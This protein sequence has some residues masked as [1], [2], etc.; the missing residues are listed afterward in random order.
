[1][2]CVYLESIIFTEL[3]LCLEIKSQIYRSILWDICQLCLMQDK[4]AEI[5]IDYM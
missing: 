3:V 5:N 1:M 2:T 4:A